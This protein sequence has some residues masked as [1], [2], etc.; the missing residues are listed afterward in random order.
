MVSR[1]EVALIIAA[2]GLQE[3][4]LLPEYFTSVI[5]VIIVT[6]LIAPPLLKYLIQGEVKKS[7]LI[8]STRSHHL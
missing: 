7:N 1:G 2:T 4:L 5:I 3:T 8:G 6:T